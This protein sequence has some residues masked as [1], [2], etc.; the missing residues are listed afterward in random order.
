MDI[1]VSRT[2]S[3]LMEAFEQLC[4]EKNLEEISV[5]EIC[6]RSTVRRN[7]FYRHFSDKY[8]FI[9][10][11]LQALAQRF[12]ADAEPESSLEGMPEYAQHMHRA[13]IRFV[14]SHEAA[15]KYALGQKVPVSTIDL[16]IKQIAEGITQRAARGLEGKRQQPETPIELLGLYYS[17]GMVHTLRWWYFEEKPFPAETLEQLCT[18]FLMRCYQSFQEA[19][20]ANGFERRA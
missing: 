18:D 16:I 7:T 15:M 13:L 4:M 6:E 2:H 5:S 8:A 10:F 1:R 14:E 17:A 20:E 12:M 9:E 3:M 11:Y 19:S